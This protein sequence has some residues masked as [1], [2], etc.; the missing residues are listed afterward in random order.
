MH[1]AMAVLCTSSLYQP[2][3]FLC[4]Y[5]YALGCDMMLASP[6]SLP[7]VSVVQW[8]NG[9]KNLWAYLVLH[10]NERASLHRLSGKKHFPCIKNKKIKKK[11]KKNNKKE[12]K[13]GR[14]QIIKVITFT[15]GFH[16]VLLVEIIHVP[17]SIVRLNHAIL[18]DCGWN[19]STKLWLI[20]I[21]H[22]EMALVTYRN[23]PILAS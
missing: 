6:S 13:K 5:G 14:K 11:K 10:A 3:P 1:L 4:I 18:W 16:Q 19:Q 9:K 23:S 17:L 7:L 2:K 12:T 20:Q 15:T 22:L 21:L 8:F